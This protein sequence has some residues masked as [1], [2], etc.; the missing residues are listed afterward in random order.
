MD[1]SNLIKIISTFSSKEIKE[2]GEFVQSP[3]F[4]KNESTVKL[5]EYIRKEYPSF[6]GEK[7]DKQNVYKKLF[8]GAEYNDGF[9]RTIIFNLSA[10]AEDFITYSA[11]KNNQSRYGILL[12]EEL[13]KRKLDKLLL[14]HLKEVEVEVN[15]M[16]NKNRDYYYYKYFIERIVYSYHN[17]SRFRKKNLKDYENEGIL[18]ETRYLLNYSLGR[19]LANY[20]FLITKSEHEHVDFHVELLDQIIK[21]LTSKN[22]D[23]LKDPSIK[24]HIY[25]ILLIREKSDKYFKILKRILHDPSEKIT[26]DEKFSLHNILQTYC[27]SKIF[28]GSSAYKHERFGLYKAALKG[29][30]YSGTEDMYFDDLLFTNIALIG[31]REGEL[32]WT[33]NFIKEFEPKLAPENKEIIVN[34]CKSRIHF[35]RKDYESALKILNCIKSI[36]HVQFKLI[37]R[38]LTLMIFYELSLFDTAYSH[39]DSYRH[40]LKSST[41]WFAQAR[42]ER[43]IN[44]LKFYYRLTKLKERPDKKSIHEL[45]YDLN[46]TPNIIERDWLSEKVK[47]LS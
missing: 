16:E 13:N 35:A 27:T 7:I 36:R 12:L 41:A 15:D 20:R 26:Q 34:Y 40:F 23:Y 11:V 32:A 22:S 28:K 9:M 38:N 4:N 45:A 14:K 18:N 46:I 3:F 43:Q 42:H 33:E 47:E 1:K 29:N 24:L 17:W 37:I 39:C 5:Y 19:T 21:F 10:L 2:F 8:P 30:Y 25:E 6:T 31:V 44:F